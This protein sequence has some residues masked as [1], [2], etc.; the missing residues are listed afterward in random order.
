MAKKTVKRLSYQTYHNQFVKFMA[1][2]NME[3]TTHDTRHTFRSELDRLNV[4]ENIIDLILGHKSSGI[5]ERVYTHKTIEELSEAVNLITYKR[6]K[7]IY[8]I[9]A[10]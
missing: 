4:K 9:S 7:K 2:M 6:D 8:V 3:H 1:K 5:G 10:S